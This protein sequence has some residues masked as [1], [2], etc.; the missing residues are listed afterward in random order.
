M[1]AME[2]IGGRGLTDDG[3]TWWW[4]RYFLYGS[5]DACERNWLW[6]RVICGA[7]G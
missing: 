2:G 3:E 6:W 4:I 5:P 1:F 7:G